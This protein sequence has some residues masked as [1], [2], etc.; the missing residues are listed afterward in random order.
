[1]KRKIL[2]IILSVLLIASTVLA[3]VDALAASKKKIPIMQVTVEG[4][5]V[6][7]GPSSEYDVMTSL[8][9][10][11]K[12]FRISKGKNSFYKVR[13]SRGLVGYMYKGFL[14]SYG[15]CYKSQ[16]Y[17]AKKKVKVYKKASTKSKRKTTLAKNQQVIV[18]QIKGKW[19]YIKTMGGKG[20]YVKK[21][22]LKKAK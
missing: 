17:T 22:A 14:K 18:Y 7:K 10:G 13:T 3:P 11:A 6:R 19:A 8:K 16:I 2:M 20:G 9:S 12:V 4:A 15:A 1:M 5:R 21:S